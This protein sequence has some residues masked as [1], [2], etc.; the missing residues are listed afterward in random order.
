MAV[1]SERGHRTD[2]QSLDA[3]SMWSRAMAH[4]LMLKSGMEPLVREPAW[5][6]LSLELDR[7]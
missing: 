6:R 5:A 4:E 7:S 1:S 2:A 3:E